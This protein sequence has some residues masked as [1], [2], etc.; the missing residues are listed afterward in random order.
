MKRAQDL[1]NRLL[2]EI[3]SFPIGNGGSVPSQ[4]FFFKL[5]NISWELNPSEFAGIASALTAIGQHEKLIYSQGRITYQLRQLLEEGLVNGEPIETYEST[6]IAI[7]GLTAQGHAYLDNR[8]KKKEGPLTKSLKASK[9]NA[10]EWV[11]RSLI[12]S[13]AKWALRIAIIF[14]APQFSIIKASYC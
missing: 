11:A 5:N 3:K 1:I 12:T 13:G 10:H 6:I 7:K 4:Y 2:D 9:A 8:R 14:T